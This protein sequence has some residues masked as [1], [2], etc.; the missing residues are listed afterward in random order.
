M[1]KVKSVLFMA[2]IALLFSCNSNVESQP[3]P[4]SPSYPSNLYESPTAGK[5]LKAKEGWNDCGP[6][7]SG[8]SYLCEDTYG[9]SA[10]PAG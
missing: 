7:G 4:P 3:P 5:Y 6:S 1:N 10:L 8:K 2:G 9:F